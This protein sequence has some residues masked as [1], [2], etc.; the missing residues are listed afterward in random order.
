MR[1]SARSLDKRLGDR[2]HGAQAPG[3]RRSLPSRSRSGTTPFEVLNH[4]KK[5][6]FKLEPAT[7]AFIADFIVSLVRSVDRAMEEE[8]RAEGASASASSG[9]QRAQAPYHMGPEPRPQIRGKII[10][11]PTEWAWEITPGIGKDGKET[12]KRTVKVN[13]EQSPDSFEREKA[14]QYWNAVRQWNSEDKTKRDR[15]R[16]L[17]GMETA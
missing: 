6:G 14:S 17:E 10:W 4:G 8:S 11:I 13:R 15:I 2:L 3:L 1:S 5:I 12:V 7:V 16:D 9:Q